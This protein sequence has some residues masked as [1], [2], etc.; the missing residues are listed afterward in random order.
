[1]CVPDRFEVAER[2]AAPDRGVDQLRNPVDAGR[3]D[4]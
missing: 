2:L 3:M 1:M 4:Q